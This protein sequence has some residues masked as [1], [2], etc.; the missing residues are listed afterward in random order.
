MDKKDISEVLDRIG[1]M[2]EIKGENPFKVRAYFSGARTLQTM[3]EDLGE[4][5]Q[6]RK[7][8][9]STHGVGGR[10]IAHG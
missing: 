1:T 8:G 10:F 6:S 4:V 5:I 2:L 7:S 9:Q 3:E